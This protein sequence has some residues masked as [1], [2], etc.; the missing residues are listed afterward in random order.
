MGTNILFEIDRFAIKGVEVF[1]VVDKIVPEGV[2]L[3]VNIININ[4]N[5][6]RSR[7]QIG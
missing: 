5:A 1:V 3:W 2:G 4:M 7:L 6:E